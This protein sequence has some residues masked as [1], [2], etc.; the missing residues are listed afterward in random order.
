[1]IRRI[2]IATDGSRQADRA[3]NYGLELAELSGAEV[4]ALYVV[5]TKANY[6]LKVNLDDN[7]MKEHEEY[8][9]ETVT[10][11]VE[12]AA[13]RGLEAK[14][15]VRKGKIAR[16]IVDYGRD[17]KIDTIV[18]GRQGSGAVDRYLGA[19]AEKVV[20]MSDIPVTIVQS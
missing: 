7:A 15:A 2:L 17:K 1:M 18:M 14:G 5:E 8:G 20:R 16:E 9:K 3:V 12:Q 11:I 4:H 6:I 10:A 19:T 13:E